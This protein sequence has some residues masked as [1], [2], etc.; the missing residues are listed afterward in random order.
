MLTGKARFDQRMVHE[1]I[2]MTQHVYDPIQIADLVELVWSIEVEFDILSVGYFVV[3]HEFSM[4]IVVVV[5][6]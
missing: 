5:Y 6:W 3:K 4:K 2:A 1:L